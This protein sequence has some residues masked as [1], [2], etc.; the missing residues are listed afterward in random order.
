[1]A[2]S[3][4]TTISTT[5]TSTIHVMSQDDVIIEARMNWQFLSLTYIFKTKIILYEKKI[6]KLNKNA[7]KF[8]IYYL[9][10]ARF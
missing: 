3:P 10:N 8:L 6:Y 1:V 4:T 9:C 7:F 2:R 5:P